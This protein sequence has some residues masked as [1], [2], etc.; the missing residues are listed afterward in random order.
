MTGRNRDFWQTL[1]EPSRQRKFKG[2]I[3]SFMRDQEEELRQL[4][5]YMNEIDDEFMHLSLAVI[6][7]TMKKRSRRSTRGEASSSQSPS[8]L[9]KIRGFDEFFQSINRDDFAWTQWVNLFQTNEPVY[10]ELVREFFASFEF[11]E[12]HSR[13]N[14][15]LEGVSFR[16]G[17]ETR[18]MS[19]LEFGWRVGLYDEEV[20]SHEDTFRITTLDIFY[21]NCIYSVR[22][23]CN[24]PFWLARYQKK[25]RT[26]N[27][28]CG[29]M[30]VTKIAKSFGL[31]GGEMFEALSVEPGAWV[32]PKKSLISTGVVMKLDRGNYVWPVIR[33]VGD[34]GDDEEDEEVRDHARKYMDM[35]SQFQYLFTR[36]NLELHLQIDPF[37]GR[38]ADYPSYGYMGH[39]PISYECCFHTAPNGPH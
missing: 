31:L 36:E 28:L 18:T 29:G 24:I 30:F 26:I 9:D 38:E 3:L 37:P 21:L 39:M 10:Q 7:M 27:V 5:E 6:E 13:T 12:Y 34:N 16:L 14:P 4:E 33:G 32:F 22:V 8:I 25:V 15:T 1:P 19:L 23:V 17:G 11:K 35:S 20:A 2:M